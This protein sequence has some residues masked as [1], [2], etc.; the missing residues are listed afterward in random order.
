MIKFEITMKEMKDVV[1]KIE[2]SVM[3]KAT[4]SI[5]ETVLVKQENNQLA[6]IASNMEEEL[7]IYKNIPVTGNDSFCIALDNLKKIVK[8][9]ADVITITYDSEDK[10]VLVSTGKKIVTFSSVWSAAE[11]FPL[12]KDIEEPEENFF[13]SNYLEFSNM[14]EKLYIYLKDSDEYKKAMTYYNFNANK[15]RVVA[16]DGHRLGMCKPS[17]KVGIFNSKSEVKEVNLNRNAW[18]KLK[19]CIAK[20]SKDAQN[21]MSIASK[22]K[23]TYI[24]GNDFRMIVRE[25]DIMYFDIDKILLSESDL[26]M[27]NVNTSELNESAEY[28]ISF[29]GKASKKPMV[30]KFIGNEIVS[31]M[32][33]ESGE[34]FDKIS[35]LDNSVSEEFMIAFNPLFVKELCSGID[36]EYVRMGFYNAKSPV[37]A[38]DG[39]FTYLVLP[40]NINTVNINGNGVEERINKLIK[41][42]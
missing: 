13:T 36:T 3:K 15:N 39:D 22:D 27:V 28:N 2:K 23:K 42:A 6:F 8:L 19:N 5:L 38:Y 41:A 20:E 32:V 29:H 21:I 4:L 31:Y 34:S 1:K 25:S 14:M 37:M 11:D 10:K 33:T 7:H 18:I 30:M 40:V 26:M 12:M 9:K 24:T 16:L 17:N 35:V